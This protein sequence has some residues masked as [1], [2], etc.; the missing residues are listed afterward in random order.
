MEIEEV[1]ITKQMINYFKFFIGDVEEEKKEEKEGEEKDKE[2][3]S[4]DKAAQA[5]DFKI[6]QE[7][8]S[9]TKNTRNG[10]QTMFEDILY[11]FLEKV[12]ESFPEEKLSANLPNFI[13]E[14]AKSKTIGAPG[15]NLGLSR[16]LQLICQLA[17]DV[18]HICKT[19]ATCVLIPLIDLE[20][21]NF[22]KIKWHSDAPAET[23][24]DEEFKEVEGHY[25]VMAHLIQK[26][27][28]DAEWMKKNCPVL[29]SEDDSLKHILDHKQLVEDIQMD[30]KPLDA[31]EADKICTIMGLD[32]NREPNY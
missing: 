10:E 32:K 15:F 3:K 17:V 5:K 7:L 13:T 30:L 27:K 18:P 28:Y 29:L 1:Q 26:H 16:F 4:E 21:V 24:E 2:A 9:T 22:A 20:M 23:E 12:F 8:H 19:F 14:M 31:D 11:C 6:M 25:K